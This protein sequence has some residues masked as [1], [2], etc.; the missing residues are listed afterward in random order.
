MGN[1]AALSASAR[2]VFKKSKALPIETTFKL[3][4]PLPSWP[5]GDGFASESIELGGLQVYQISSFSKVWATHEGT[6]QPWGKL[7]RTFTLTESQPNNKPLSGW[8]LAA[9]ST[10]DKD[11][12]EDDHPLLKKPLDYTLVWNSESLKTLKKE[13]DGYVW[14]PTPPHGYEAIGHVVTSSPEKPSLDQIRCVR[15]DHTDHCEADS[16]I[17]ARYRW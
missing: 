13:G 1:C 6:R 9:K 11:E 2:G 3:P 5:P 15:S 10:K 7:L 14:L 4:A 16:W 8:A 12:D 17:W